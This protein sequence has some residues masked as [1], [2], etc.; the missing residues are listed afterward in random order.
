[1]TL[2]IAGLAWLTLAAYIV[3]KMT[4]R[5]DNGLCDILGLMLMTAVTAA[6]FV[7]MTRSRKNGLF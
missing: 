1:M 7:F 2:C 6:A 3:Y 5:P 4:T